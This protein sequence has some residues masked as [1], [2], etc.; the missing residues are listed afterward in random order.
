MLSV[1]KINYIH[2]HYCP[3]LANQALLEHTTTDLVTTCIKAIFTRLCYPVWQRH[4]P[5]GFLLV[6]NIDLAF[7]ALKFINLSKVE[8]T[9]AEYNFFGGPSLQQDLMHLY[10]QLQKCTKETWTHWNL[11]K[12]DLKTTAPTPIESADSLEIYSYIREENQNSKGHCNPRNCGHSVET[13]SL[14]AMGKDGHKPQWSRASA[15]W[16][17]QPREVHH[18]KTADVSC[19]VF[20]FSHLLN[21]F[22]FFH[23]ISWFNRM[24]TSQSALNDTELQ[25]SLNDQCVNCGHFFPSQLWR[26]CVSDWIKFWWYSLIKSFGL[27][28]VWGFFVLVWI[29]NFFWGFIYCLFCCCCCF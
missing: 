27:I 22:V 17:Y 24:I 20:R 28:L 12:V 25:M 2:T 11:L 26:T 6:E 15:A 14:C 21:N 16:S 4:P 18:R 1:R 5:V 7:W 13:T 29:G 9:T 23:L 8:R 10:S 19:E 3:H